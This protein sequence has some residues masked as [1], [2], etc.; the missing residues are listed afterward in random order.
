VVTLFL[1]RSA[2]SARNYKGKNRTANYPNISSAIRPVSHTEGLPVPVPLQQ[3]ILD[4][5]DEPTENREKTPQPLISADAEFTADL[6]LNE[7]HRITQHELN[8]PIRDLDLRK[9]KAELLGSRLQQ[10]DLL[11]ENVRVS[12]YRERHEDLVQS[13]KMEKGLVVYTDIDGLM[14]TLNINHN[15]LDWRLL[16]DS[17]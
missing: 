8:D 14:Q 11:T 5:G 15:P 13:F 2:T 6:Q 10:W 3:V 9:R 16:I 12:V 4:S 7:F 1:Y 17:C